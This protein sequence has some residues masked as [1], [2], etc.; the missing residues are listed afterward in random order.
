MWAPASD[1][2]DRAVR[3]LENGGARMWQLGECGSPASAPRGLRTTRGTL[4]GGVRV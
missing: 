2:P 4:K 1:P 3:Q